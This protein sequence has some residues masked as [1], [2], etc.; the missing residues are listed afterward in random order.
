LVEAVD[1]VAP[2]D[3]CPGD[4]ESVE[5]EVGLGATQM[6]NSA[7]TAAIIRPQ[8]MFMIVLLR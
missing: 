4:E 7:P 2:E 3:S 5:A 8:M 1:S 6:M